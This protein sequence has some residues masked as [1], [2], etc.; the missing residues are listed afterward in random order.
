MIKSVL[1]KEW[2]KT[3]W[4]FLG[5]L[6]LWLMVVVYVYIDIAHQLKFY[7]ASVIWYNIV[8][9][10][11][12]YYSVIFYIPLLSGLLLGLT[13]FVPEITDKRLKL[14]LHLPVKE[15]KMLFTMIGAGGIL[16]FTLYAFSLIGLIIVSSIYFPSNITYSMLFTIA[17]WYF[18]GIVVYFSS[19][20]IILEP[21]WVRRILY[22][23]VVA[24]F[25]DL[26]LQGGWYCLYTGSLLVFLI[27]SL[28]F[29]LSVII[30]GYRFKR[31]VMK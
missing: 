13:Q 14:T 25:I 29:V 17:P 18:A 8:F 11:L 19:A 21:I 24:G 12:S 20:M 28:F 2:L 15:N 30:T 7:E 10:G 23:P 1:F 5:L 3:K 31:G 26:L 27:L 4:T 6:A 9:L 16:L 22:I